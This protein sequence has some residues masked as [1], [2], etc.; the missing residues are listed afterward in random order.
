MNELNFKFRLY[1][2]AIVTILIWSLLAWSYYHGGVPVHHVLARKDLPGISNWWGGL[3][4]P[5]FSWFLLY[6][7]QRRVQKKNQTNNDNILSAFAGAFVF[8]ILVSFFFTLGYTEIPGYMLFG[9]LFLAL[10]LPVYRAEFLLGF[11]IGM[12]FTFGAI[13][14]IISGSV[15]ALIAFL[16]YHLI[17]PGILFIKSLMK[18]GSGPA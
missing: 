11:V 1:F 12:T 16:I 7:I 15:L 17:R 18:A 5:L 2:T 13:L 3:F 8:G 6:R 4:L 10:Y 14:P 9:L